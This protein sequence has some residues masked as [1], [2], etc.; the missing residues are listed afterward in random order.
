MATISLTVIRAI[1]AVH[2]APSDPPEHFQSTDYVPDLGSNFQKRYKL[3]M[4]YKSIPNLLSAVDK[5]FK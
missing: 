5:V 2:R 4:A 3:S 1:H